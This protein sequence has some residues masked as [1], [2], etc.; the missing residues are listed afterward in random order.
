MNGAILQKS[1]P[2]LMIVDIRL[3]IEN[4]ESEKITTPAISKITGMRCEMRERF[5]WDLTSLS[6]VT[7]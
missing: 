5:A 6:S 2:P 1:K 7:K 3:S 4:I